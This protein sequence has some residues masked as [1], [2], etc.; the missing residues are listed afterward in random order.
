MGTANRLIR[1]IADKFKEH[2]SRLDLLRW[3]DKEIAVDNLTVDEFFDKL[4]QRISDIF[5][6]KEVSAHVKADST[7]LPITQGARLAQ[8]VPNEVTN[9]EC[10]SHFIYL[11]VNSNTASLYINIYP[12]ETPP[13]ALVIYDTYV[14]EK[15]SIIHDDDFIDFMKAVAGQSTILLNSHIQ[16]SLELQRDEVTNAFFAALIDRDDKNSECWGKIAE[17]FT[18]FLPNWT[19][20]KLPHP[21]LVQILSYRKKMPNVIT[22]KAS[23]ISDSDPLPTEVGKL[24]RKDSTICGLFLERREIGD[25]QD[26]YLYIDPTEQNLAER[27]TSILFDTPPRSEL[28]VP[29]IYQNELVGLINLEHAEKGAFHN[30]H[31]KMIQKGVGAL[32]PLVQA[33]T[34]QEDDH[35]ANSYALRYILARILDKMGKLYRHKV[36]QDIQNAAFAVGNLKSMAGSISDDETQLHDL[37]LSSVRNLDSLTSSYFARMPN[38]VTYGQIQLWNT[39]QSAAAD[40]DPGEM[41]SSED[42]SLTLEQPD[43]QVNILGSMLMQEHFYNV[44]NNALQAIRYRQKS[45]QIKRGVIRVFASIVASQDNTGKEASND[46]A[47]VS[48]E[49]NGGGIST[50]NLPS[51]FLPGFSTKKGDGGT[52]FGLAA[53]RSYMR[54]IGGDVTIENN[55]SGGA[56]AKFLCPIFDERYHSALVQSLNAP[57]QRKEK[58][59]K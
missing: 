27:Y 5:H 42:I 53:A 7:W 11:D 46:L 33:M 58:N 57:A 25:L 59:A 52:G 44:I 18:N 41:E 10:G 15:N 34:A 21:P 23:R 13:I 8:N 38:F 45:G 55:D 56:T 9:E 54:E 19:P 2:E 6:I 36:K 22:L 1:E 17:M 39:I 51:V 28:V 50:S 20:F 24:L 31:I 43:D 16:R 4:A 12:D 3:I 49:D 47:I 40:F 26:E 29:I 35:Y 37:L 32:A 48:I 14:E 30:Y